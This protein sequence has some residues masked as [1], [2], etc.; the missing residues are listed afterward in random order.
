MATLTPEEILYEE[1]HI[2]DDRRPMV[3]AANATFLAIT[4]IAVALRFW[5][6]RL[7]RTPFGLD[8]AMI[9]LAEVLLLSNYLQFPA[10]SF[11]TSRS[12]TQ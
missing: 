7:A 4:V 10:V 6:R 11:R 1:Q 12:K 9:I 8:D 5:S 3:A 2:N